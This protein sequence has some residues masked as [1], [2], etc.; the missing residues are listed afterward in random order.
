M[1]ASD[2]GYFDSINPATG[3]VWARVPAATADDV[4]RAVDSAYD[5]FTNGPWSRMTPTE[6]GH[7]LRRLGDL[8]AEKSEEFG[9]IE[10]I[11]TGKLFKETRWQAKY[12]AEFFHFYAGAADKIHGETLP[13][14]KPDF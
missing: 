4:N 7:C 6:R 13:I 10:A 8:L 2:G 12:I 11:D 14:D 3:A 9:R 1:A 5:A